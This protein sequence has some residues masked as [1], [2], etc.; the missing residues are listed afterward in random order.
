VENLDASSDY[1]AFVA[2]DVDP[3]VRNAAFKK[4][5]HSDPHFNVMDGLDVYIDDY[6]TPNPLPVAVMKT[7]VQARALGLIDDELKEQD[8]PAPDPLPP[9]VV[10][11]EPVADDAPVSGEAQT[12]E[13]EL[14]ASETTI[15][16]AEPAV[17]LAEPGSTAEVVHVL[18][19][20]PVYADVNANAATPLV[21][22]PALASSP[23]TAPGTVVPFPRRPGSA[24]PT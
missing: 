7:L 20:E 24:D 6:N 3:Q 15:L 23:S 18:H 4:M 16:E 17:Q 2:R 1:R 19:V 5:F 12:P 11:E 22:G 21:S 10:A 8:L 14:N 13:A 9:A